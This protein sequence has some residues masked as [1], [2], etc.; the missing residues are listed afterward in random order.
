[1]KSQIRLLFIA[2]LGLW[3]LGGCGSSMT[4]Y[5]KFDEG[6]E[7]TAHD[8]IGS[9][10]GEISGA[11]WETGVSGT[12]LSFDG[13]DDYVQT[14]RNID[15]GGSTD[16]T[17]VAWVYPTSTSPGR[18]QVISSDDGG[19][20][21]SILRKGR[22]WHAFTGNG[23]WNSGF[24]VDVNKWQHIA[25]VFKPGE[26]VIF[27]KNAVNRLRGSAPAADTNDNN[28]AIGNNPG[29]WDEYFKGKIDEVAIYNNVLSA[30]QIQQLY[31]KGAGRAGITCEDAGI[32]G[33]QMNEIAEIVMEKIK[34]QIHSREINQR[35]KAEVEKI[36]AETRKLR[37]EAQKFDVETQK[38]RE[39]IRLLR[40]EAEKLQAEAENARQ[41]ARKA[42]AETEQLKAKSKTQN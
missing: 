35:E 20:D 14:T 4:S 29:H 1:M 30:E 18:H 11:A 10:D 8:S 37:Q 3:V 5:W 25:A 26:D 21:W 2:I 12:S 41:Q 19:F 15:Q 32:T 42:R 22:K 17:M 38:L 31:Q 33:E 7:T 16:I 34:L 28:I 13:R 23:S 39:E 9:N 27:Y 24:T 40:A 6:R 36:R